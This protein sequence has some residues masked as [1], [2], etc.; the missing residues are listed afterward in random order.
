MGERAMNED[1][2]LSFRESPRPEFTESLF[3]KLTKE[4]KMYQV[5]R[6]TFLIKRV[7]LVFLALIL[8]FAITL[9]I[10]PA[11]R[12]AVDEIIR[13]IMVRGITVFVSSDEPD[14]SDLPEVSE[15]YSILWSPASPDEISA[16][17]PFFA[18]IPAWVPSGYELQDQAAL[19]YPSMYGPPTSSVF[20]WKNNAGDM[21]ELGV[22]KG[23]CPNGPF[24]E[25]GA[26]RSDCMI[27]IGIS[28]GEK[29][30]PQVIKVHDQPGVFIRVA[31]GFADLSG[32]VHEWNPGRW[33]INK[34]PTKGAWIIWENDERTFS[35]VASSAAITK[36]DMIRVAESI[37]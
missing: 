12:A 36:E 9:A 5:T 21:I 31:Y 18:K 15:T 23:A 24:Y 2:F 20:Q 10:S 16:D 32:P 22:N 13:E 27:T 30:E 35:L 7:S 28:V 33:K 19:Y 37:P 6:R 1:F 4:T 26:P 8:A 17:F 3:Y 34:D 14:Y 25:S 11:V 29:S